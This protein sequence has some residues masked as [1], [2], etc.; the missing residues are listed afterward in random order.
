MSEPYQ[1]WLNLSVD[2]VVPSHTAKI[3]W[4]RAWV[5]DLF[6]LVRCCR[7]CNEFLNGYRMGATP[8]PTDVIGFIAIRDRVFREKFDHAAR[9]HLLERDRYEKARPAGPMDA[10]EAIEAV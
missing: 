4:P 3:D 8:I 1:A 9:R 10:Q 7:A 5:L 2:H 6:N